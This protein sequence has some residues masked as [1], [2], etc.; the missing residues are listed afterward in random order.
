MYMYIQKNCIW[1]RFVI[2]SGQSMKTQVDL[3][4]QVSSCFLKEVIGI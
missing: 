4:K 2:T 1:T 3:K